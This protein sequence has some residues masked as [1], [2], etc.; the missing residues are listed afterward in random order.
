MRSAGIPRAQN[1]AP[2]RAV[3]E[4]DPH[5][6]AVF[7]RGEL[8]DILGVVTRGGPFCVNQVHH[9]EEL[10]HTGNAGHA[11]APPRRGSRVCECPITTTGR[12]DLASDTAR[13]PR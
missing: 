6:L 4:D 7:E 11:M 12:S 10:H 5:I 1:V 13:G 3:I 8:L 9:T 2:A